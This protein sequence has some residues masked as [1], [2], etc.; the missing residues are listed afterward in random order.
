MGINA[1]LID[2]VIIRLHAGEGRQE[3]CKCE[4]QGSTLL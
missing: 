3:G 1:Q 2:F 4:E